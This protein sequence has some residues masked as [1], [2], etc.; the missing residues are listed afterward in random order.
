MWALNGRR[1]NGR[2]S[3]R[4]GFSEGRTSAHSGAPNIKRRIQ[5]PRNHLAHLACL[6]RTAQLHLSKAKMKPTLLA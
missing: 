2:T 3:V 5:Q 4:G 6:T 1:G